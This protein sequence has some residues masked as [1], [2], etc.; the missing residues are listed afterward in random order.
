MHFEVLAEDQSGSIALDVLLQKI[1]GRNGADHSWKLHPYKGIG[2]IPANLHEAPN[3][4]TRLLLHHLPALLRG[5]GRS[6]AGADAC[7]VVVADLD[8]RDCIAFKKDLVDVLN[9]C[10]PR[11][12]TLFRIAIEE[13]EA[14]LLG[15]RDAVKAAY[16]NARDSVLNGYVQDSICGTWE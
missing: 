7:V 16:P 11:P 4:K 12:R 13:S 6:L 3:P 8:D 5:Y 2:R 9:A 14:W 10:N 15:D 1:L